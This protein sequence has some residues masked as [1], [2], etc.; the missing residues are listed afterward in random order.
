MLHS[1]LGNFGKGGMATP[2]PA[3]PE[4]LGPTISP[5]EENAILA[6]TLPVPEPEVSFLTR[7]AVPLMLGGGVLLLGTLGMVLLIKV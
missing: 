7:N 4:D 2:P 6:A 1:R 3:P 5:E